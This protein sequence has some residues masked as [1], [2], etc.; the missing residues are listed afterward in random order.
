[1]ADQCRDWCGA[2]VGIGSKKKLSIAS[3]FESVK[4]E[5]ILFIDLLILG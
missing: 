4:K 5:I 3:I 1:M 2:C